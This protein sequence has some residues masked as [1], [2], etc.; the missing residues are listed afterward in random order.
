[1]T[2]RI[3]IDARIAGS[4]TG[5][6]AE[7]LLNH[8]QAIDTKN[9]Y[10]V[11]LRKEGS[12]TPTAKNFRTV[13]APF[14][15]YTF[16]EQFGF[17]KLLYSLKPDLVH[18]I[19]PQ[20]PLLYIGKRVT[21][22]HDLTLVR[23]ENIDM[24]PI[25]YKIRKGIFTLLLRNVVRRSKAVLTGTE[26]VRKDVLAF[27][28]MRYSDKVITTL[29]A[30]DPLAGKSEEI[31]E[32]KGKKFIFFVGNAFPYKNLR[33]IVEGY[34]SVKTTHPEL[35]LVFA[36]KKDYFYEQI[37]EFVNQNGVKDVHILGFI[38]EGAK[39]WLFQ[40]A[41]AYVVASLSEGFHIPGLE[42]MY[43]G[44]PVISSSATCLPEV[45]ADA[46][47]YFDPAS[48]RELAEAITDILEKPKLRKD[49]VTR[50][51][52]RVKQFSWARM[53]QETKD[54]YDLVLNK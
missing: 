29:E 6:Y 21:T 44:C 45:Y 52:E 43:E 11:L 36:G 40:N 5:V 49:L 1:M 10:V 39:R 16:S 3:V 26:Y 27:T 22:V 30:G 18:F 17:A 9:E 54:V 8:L 38:S 32:L 12:W 48:T 37:E 33:R 42:A 2:K 24:N 53:A 35:E 15:D 4:S 34:M 46:A 25:V 47:R 28:S 14:K 23:Y 51:H 50:G 13:V 20:Q 31:K 41:E 19:M 7:N